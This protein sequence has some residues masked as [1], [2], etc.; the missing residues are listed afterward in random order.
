MKATLFL[1]IDP[2]CSCMD[3]IDVLI[4]GMDQLLFICAFITTHE[5]Q[6]RQLQNECDLKCRIMP[7]ESNIMMFAIKTTDRIWKM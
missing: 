4:E 3:Q 2:L 6:C 1:F 5:L 7:P